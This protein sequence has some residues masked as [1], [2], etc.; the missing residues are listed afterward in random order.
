MS[1]QVL[2]ARTSRQRP[3]GSPSHVAAP[4]S[5]AR[6]PKHCFPRVLSIRRPVCSPPFP[7]CK[8]KRSA[9][10]HRAGRAVRPVGPL[11]GC[12]ARAAAA[13]FW[14]AGGPVPL[15]AARPARRRS[16]RA[17]RR[18]D[19]LGKCRPLL[20]ARKQRPRCSRALLPSRAR[21]SSGVPELLGQNLF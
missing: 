12:N 10:H 8:F 20:A 14:R 16:L 7:R 5:G 3:V 13:P 4:T 21:G 11:D 18:A 19:A 15:V 2:A 6:T 1:K 17:P 9:S